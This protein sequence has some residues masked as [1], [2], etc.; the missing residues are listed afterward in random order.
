MYCVSFYVVVGNKLYLILSYYFDELVV[1]CYCLVATGVVHSQ[2][3]VYLSST[4]SSQDSD[5]QCS[6][7][8][9]NTDQTTGLHVAAFKKNETLK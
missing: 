9:Q 1:I 6:S 8:L 5:R 7:V 2:D 4:S 3:R